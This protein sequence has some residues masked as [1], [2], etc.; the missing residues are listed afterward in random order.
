MAF[1]M[2]PLLDFAPDKD[3]TQKGVVTD[4]SGFGPSEKGFRTL[5]APQVAS[6]ALP[7]PAQGGFVAH[8]Q[9]GVI[10]VAGTSSQLYIL[11]NGHWI[12][13]GLTITTSNNRWRFDSY[14]NDIIA[15]NG[16]DPPF[17]SSNGAN[18]IPLAGSPP[19]ADLVQSSDYSIFL[20]TASSFTWWSTLSDIIWTPG[21]PTETVTADITASP[22][23]LTALKSL[24]STM[25][26]YKR[27][28]MYVGYFTQPPFFWNLQKI[29]HQVGVAS[30]EG[31]INVN[32]VH[33]FLGPDDFYKFDGYNLDRI[34]NSLK[35]WFFRESFDKA[36]DYTVCTRYDDERN[37]IFWHYSSVD[38]NPRGSLDAWVVLN[39]R[40]GRWARGNDLIQITLDGNIPSAQGLTY[41][42]FGAMFNTYN[43]IPN[44]PY[45]WIGFGS[46]PTNFSAVFLPDNALYVYGQLPPLPNPGPYITGSDFGD[47]R[48]MYQVRRLR[49]SFYLHPGENNSQVEVLQQY[50]AG[51]LPTPAETVPLSADG[52]YN[53]N[54]TARLQRHRIRVFD[55]A[56]IIQYE[57]EY[58]P[59]GEV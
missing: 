51:T 43:D 4:C 27:G 28:S 22:G 24:R 21:I 45:N 49:P 10:I 20:D 15:V 26:F 3:P 55:S 23:N 19:I 7:L 48:L 17:V 44:I 6:P 58:E 40:T 41:D 14:G 47:R 56:E 54:V 32:D 57:C 53:I 39:V 46:S 52:F 9:A 18:F 25:V 36:F 34:P 35:E 11:R 37:L 13:Q 30:Y 5:P 38:A 8:V 50:V 12:D 59:A 16:V 31:V 42:Q 29:S 1:D 2:R 33:Y